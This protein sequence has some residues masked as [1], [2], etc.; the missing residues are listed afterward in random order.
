M[1]A[2]CQKRTLA[3]ISPEWMACWGGRMRTL[4]RRSK[5]ISRIRSINMDPF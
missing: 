1:S 2:K 3:S 5:R 4:P